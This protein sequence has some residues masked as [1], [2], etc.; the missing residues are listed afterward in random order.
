MKF[1]NLSEG[2]EYTVL[3]NSCQEGQD[4]PTLN[5]LVLPVNGDVLED[6]V[7]GREAAV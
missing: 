3:I 2:T 5:I 6:R 7:P 1:F 4:I